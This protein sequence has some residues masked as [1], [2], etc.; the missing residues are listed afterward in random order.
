MLV[1]PG[2]HSR[3]ALHELRLVGE[4]T[5]NRLQ[6]ISHR[7]GSTVQNG[8]PLV[9]LFHRRLDRGAAL[10]GLPIQSSLFPERAN[11]FRTFRPQ[12]ILQRDDAVLCRPF[13]EQLR[14]DAFKIDADV[15]VF[16]PPVPNGGLAGD[17][18]RLNTRIPSMR[19]FSAALVAEAEAVVVVVVGAEVA[20]VSTMMRLAMCFSLHA[21]YCFGTRNDPDCQ[22][23]CRMWKHIPS[24]FTQVEGAGVRDGSW[25]GPTSVVRGSQ[26][27]SG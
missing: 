3:E 16:I 9:D 5:S 17:T 14:I 24:P 22:S 25:H 4:L 6:H 15:D 12:N 21:S 20:W 8:K 11:K 19:V 7:N 1:V 18:D 10:N 2:I 26:Y 13:Q 27:A 23:L